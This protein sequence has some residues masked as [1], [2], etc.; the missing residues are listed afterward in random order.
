M[1]TLR[2]W[3]LNEAFSF[4]M[5]P[6]ILQLNVEEITNNILKIYREWRQLYSPFQIFPWGRLAFDITWRWHDENLKP[7]PRRLAECLYKYGGYKLSSAF[8]GNLGNELREKIPLTPQFIIRITNDFSWAAGAFGDNGSC[9]W[10]SRA[11]TRKAMGQSGQFL[12]LQIFDATQPNNGRS[13]SINIDGQ[14][15]WSAGRCWVYPTTVKFG[16]E[17]EAITVIFNSYGVH[18][19]QQLGVIVQGLMETRGMKRI[20]VSNNGSTGGGIYVNSGGGILVGSARAL[21][22]IDHIDFSFQSRYDSSNRRAQEGL[23][24]TNTG[25]ILNSP[26]RIP[27]KLKRRGKRKTQYQCQVD[28]RKYKKEQLLQ[29]KRN[30]ESGKHYRHFHRNDG[31]NLIQRYNDNN[32]G[33]F[34]NLVKKAARMDN[35]YRGTTPSE[36]HMY[37]DNQSRLTQCL[38]FTNA[39]EQE[40]PR[41]SKRWRQKYKYFMAKNGY[42]IWPWLSYQ[43]NQLIKEV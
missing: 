28:I 43:F 26:N 2:D 8:W 30:K 41:Q 27:H 22:I 39:Y 34:S 31:Y 42:N 11:T 40:F 1:K 38:W 36:I 12:A 24:R 10:D 35:L 6:S 32:I 4:T 37:S 18:P 25:A 29:W 16:E 15:Y 19:L 9:M 17:E 3:P 5:P 13:Y 23:M 7:L 14:T 21:D 20:S 33:R